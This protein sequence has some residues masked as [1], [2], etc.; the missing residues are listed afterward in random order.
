[1]ADDSK[2]AWSPVFP[3]G[4]TS[5]QARSRRGEHQERHAAAP[6][7]SVGEL[8]DDFLGVVDSGFARDRYGRPF[9]PEAAQELHWSLGGHVSEEL[10]A[11]R[12]TDLSRTDVEALIYTLADGG[13]PRRRLRAL[14][15]SV[16]AL[17]DY[18]AEL[19]LVRYNPAERVAIPDEDEAQQPT[20]G[21]VSRRITGP[22]QGTLDR[23]IAVALRLATLGLLLLAVFLLAASI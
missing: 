17:Y 3:R 14:A 5:G 7:P 10:G 2:P 20:A 8:V 18:A 21:D 4:T 15:K 22:A 1:M 6:S 9:S 11:T 19:D 23:G 12:L 13:V 16:R